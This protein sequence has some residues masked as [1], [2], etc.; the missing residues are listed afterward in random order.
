MDFMKD[1]KKVI[2]RGSFNIN[3]YIFNYLLNDHFNILHQEIRE[4]NNKLLCFYYFCIHTIFSEKKNS[5]CKSPSKSDMKTQYITV[6]IPEE[7]DTVI[8]EI[9][10]VIYHKPELFISKAIQCQWERIKSDIDA[11]W[12]YVIDDFC[13]IVRINHVLEE[14]LKQSKAKKKFKK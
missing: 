4:D 8:K 3:K 13:D 2:I 7:Y 9:C 14:L 10:D 1:A 12:Y 6:K 5:E 11:G